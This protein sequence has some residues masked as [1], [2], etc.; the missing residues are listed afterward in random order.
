M[1]INRKVSP[2]QVFLGLGTTLIL[3]LL[4]VINLLPFKAKLAV[5]KGLGTLMYRIPNSRIAVTRTN[6]KLCFPELTQ[7][8]REE[9]VRD[10][11][12]NFGAGLIE[13]AMGWWDDPQKIFS[14]TES[15]GQEV[16]DRA[17][18]Q[19][20]GVIL[21]GAHF[22]TLDLSSLLLSK[23]YQYYAIYREQTN[24]LLNWFMTRGRSR[25]MLGGIPHTSMRGAAKRIMAGDIVWY[26]PDQDM[27]HDHSVFA[28]FFGQQAATV[29]ATAKIAKL[30]GAPLVML[31][32]YRKPDDSGYV[33]HFLSGPDNFPV[34]DEVQNATAVNSLIEQGIRISP[35]QY[36]WFH[37]RFKTQLGFEKGAIYQ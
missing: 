27:G 19:G 30:T 18:E 3:L 31:V 24:R 10:T 5:G 32:S 22:S 4:W 26:S 8:Q 28:P 20:K 11:F 29:T 16:L 1:T 33:V 2:G 17:L 23:Y 36:Y 37:R 34:D 6:L 21:V 13:T 25:N 12:K 35:A 15:V 9:M 14:M 7:D